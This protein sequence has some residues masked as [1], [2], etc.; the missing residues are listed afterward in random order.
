VP[1]LFSFKVFNVCLQ[2]N[3]TGGFARDKTLRDEFAG[4]ALPLMLQANIGKWAGNH[5]TYAEHAA[6]AIEYLLY[7]TE[8]SEAMLER[9]TACLDMPIG[10]RSCNY[11]VVF[12]F[13]PPTFITSISVLYSSIRELSLVIRTTL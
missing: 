11:Y 12:H 9:Q 1:S 13:V 4:L 2:V 6:E 10:V 5:E 3:D 8:E 7:V